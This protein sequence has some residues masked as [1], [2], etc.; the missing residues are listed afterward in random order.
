[1]AEW[2]ENQDFWEQYAPIMFEPV[3]WAEAPGVAQAI[4]KIALLPS[5]A[6]ILDAGCGPGRIAVELGLLGYDVT[7]VDLVSSYL[8]AADESAKDENVSVELVQADLREFVRPS[9]FDVAI[10]LY[11]SFGYC[12]SVEEDLQIL[13]NISKSIKPHGWFVLETVSKEIAVR[14]FTEGEWFERGGMTVLTEFSVKGAWEGLRSKWILIKKDGSRIE[15]EFV[16][17]LYAATELKGLLLTA[18]FESVETY[19]DFE[20]SPFNEKAKTCVL[21]CRKAGE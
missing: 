4:C 8:K 5:G 17:R 14:D 16:Q 18:G 12:D 3:R 2:F 9:Y 1:M 19:G 11:T 15:H 6:K 13:K 7:G 21:V 20:F 10:N